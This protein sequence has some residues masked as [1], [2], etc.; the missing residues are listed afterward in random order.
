MSVTAKRGAGAPARL[1]DT[2]AGT[3][4]HVLETGVVADAL[5]TAEEQGRICALAAA[6]QRDL[7]DRAAAYPE[8]FPP[9][10]FDATLFGTVSLATAFGA[11]WCDRDQ[12]RV[13]NRAALWIFA[14]DWLIDHRA[15]TRDEVDSITRRCLRVVDGADAGSDPLGRFLAEIRDE[16]A[17]TTPGAF[18]TA[19]PA[20]R[21]EFRRMLHAMAREWDWKQR[22]GT[23]GRATNPVS[24]PDPGLAAVAGPASGPLPDLDEYL[25]NAD[26]FGSSF[27]N[28]SH[29]IR[30]GDPDT[31]RHLPELVAASRQVQRVLRLVNDLA[32]HQR[33]VRW[34]DLN[35]LRLGV[36][37]AEVTR[38]IE[39][40]V[41]RCHESFAALP[42]PCRAQGGYLARQIG[43]STGFYQ[44]TDFWGRS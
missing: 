7:A 32:T 17:E 10:P 23:A 42:F 4:A 16:L 40:L 8:L 30:T 28:V 31:L 13:A 29:W 6:G 33:D 25:A 34:G 26:N 24:G 19:R 20:W 18:A 41:Q 11:P 39:T 1:R 35:A 12:L 36:D 2:G 22:L 3:D 5:R 38:R 43:F 37:R 21:E 9:G 44:L 15:R 27:V 14:A